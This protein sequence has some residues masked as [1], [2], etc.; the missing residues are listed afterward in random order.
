MGLAGPFC[1]GSPSRTLIRV[2]KFKF[3][4]SWGKNQWHAVDTNFDALESQTCRRYEHLVGCTVIRTR[5]I[6]AHTVDHTVET[7]EVIFFLIDIQ[8]LF[9][10][11]L[12]TWKIR[13]HAIFLVAVLN[14]ISYQ[15]L[16]HERVRLLT[17]ITLRSNSKLQA[18]KCDFSWFIY[19]YRRSTCFR[20][21]LRPSSGAHNC[22]YS[23]RYCQPI[24]V[25]AAIVEEMNLHGVRSPLR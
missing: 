5:S 13:M 8:I 11:S 21:F 4:P 9:E 2:L 24:L 19:F 25:L 12:R 10:I 3:Q 15:S 7:N 14:A 6:Q 17:Y 16:I 23:F 20:L 1:V 18:T 22:T